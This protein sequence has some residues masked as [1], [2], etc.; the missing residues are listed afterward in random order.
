MARLFT[1]ARR[2]PRPTGGVIAIL[3]IG[4]WVGRGSRR[5][6]WLAIMPCSRGARRRDLHHPVRHGAERRDYN[7]NRTSGLGVCSRRLKVHAVAFIF[8]T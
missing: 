6:E 7:G 4:T 3:S 5:A 8:V 2:E 1:A